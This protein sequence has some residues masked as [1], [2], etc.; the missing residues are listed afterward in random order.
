MTQSLL[1]FI[2]AA[3]VNIPISGI[4]FELFVDTFNIAQQFVIVVVLYEL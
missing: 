2:G 4:L 1:R 3:D